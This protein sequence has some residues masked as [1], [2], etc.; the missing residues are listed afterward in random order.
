MASTGAGEEGSTSRALGA[1]PT[2]SSGAHIHRIHRTDESGGSAIFAIDENTPD[3][4]SLH[5]QLRVYVMAGKYKITGLKQLARKRFNA[6]ATALFRDPI[7]FPAVMDEVFSTTTRDADLRLRHMVCQ[8][9]SQLWQ[10]EHATPFSPQM[11]ALLC[12]YGELGMGVLRCIRGLYP[13]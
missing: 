2:S 11:D 12:K 5:V 6:T 9:V 1:L 10:P 3:K 13:E 4:E 8:L 7:L